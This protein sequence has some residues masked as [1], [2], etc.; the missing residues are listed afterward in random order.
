MSGGVK[1]VTGLGLALTR[2]HLSYNPNL[3]WDWATVGRWTLRDHWL[4]RNMEQSMCW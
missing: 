2:Y 3:S 1:F 4:S